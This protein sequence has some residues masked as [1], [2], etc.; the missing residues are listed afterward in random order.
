MSSA[1]ERARGALYGLAIGDALGMPTQLMSYDEVVAC[2]GVLDGFREPADDHR[3]AAGRPAGSITDDTE[4]ALLVADVLLADSGHIDSE[5]LARRLLAWAERAR[6][7]GSLDLLGPSSSAA[8]AALVAGGPLD[9]AGGFGATNGAAMRIA[10]VGLVATTDD[11][12]GLVDLVVEASRVTHHTGVAIAGAAAVAAAVS[13]G[14][15]GASAAEAT[16]V[17]IHAAELGQR[18]GEW[19]AGASIARRITWAMSLVDAH[20]HDRSVRDIV[21][22]VGTSLATQES[23]PAAF[24]VLALH[25]DDPWQACLTAAS[26]GGDSDT[27]AAM[28]GAI[29]GACHGM[30]RWPHEAVRTVCEINNLDLE[31]LAANLLALRRSS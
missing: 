14:I 12:D 6:E 30:D 18:R 13:A 2:F 27:I 22:L 11:L 23:V 9:E 24:A 28:T 5:D 17:G 15:G 4:Q 31:K 3:I 20:D 8:V 26:L 7:R 21:E 16:T 1:I 29:A 25:P 10:P 19:F